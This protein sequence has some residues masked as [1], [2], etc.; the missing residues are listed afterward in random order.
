[1]LALVLLP[2]TTCTPSQNMTQEFC[3][4]N[5]KKINHIALEQGLYIN[6]IT[7]PSGRNVVYFFNRTINK[8]T[9]ELP[10]LKNK[11]NTAQD[12][13]ALITYGLACGFSKENAFSY[14]NKYV[15]DLIHVYEKKSLKKLL[16]SNDGSGL[17]L[18]FGPGNKFITFCP[19]T[20]MIKSVYWKKKLNLSISCN[21]C[22]YEGVL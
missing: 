5:I 7:L 8:K 15:S 13:I 12:T 20:S 2:L 10:V 1:M 3:C 4:E 9:F 21:E 19:D 11:H 22:W 18:F 17:V 16:S 14:S 6:T